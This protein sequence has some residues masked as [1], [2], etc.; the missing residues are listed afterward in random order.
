[1][2]RV[3]SHQ[4]DLTAVI[5]CLLYLVLLRCGRVGRHRSALCERPA[6]FPV[7]PPAASQRGRGEPETQLPEQH[8]QT[9]EVKAL[10]RTHMQ[11]MLTWHKHEVIRKCNTIGHFFGVEQNL[12]VHYSCLSRRVLD[13]TPAS[14]CRARETSFTSLQNSISNQFQVLLCSFDT[15]L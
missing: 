5:S 11:N 13:S 15:K 2:S 4:A 14:A 1:M 10:A 6:V 3:L 7:P 9:S 8:L 12:V